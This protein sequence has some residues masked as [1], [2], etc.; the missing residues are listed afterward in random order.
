MRFSVGR[1]ID[2]LTELLRV[3]ADLFSRR[4]EASDK[5]WSEIVDTRRRLSDALAEGRVSDAAFLRKKL[6]GL[7]RDYRRGVRSGMPLAVPAVAAISSVLL[8]GCL[9]GRRGDDGSHSVFV[10]GDRVM[11]ADPGSE[12]VIPDLIPP[13]RQWYIVDDVG[14]KHWLGVDADSVETMEIPER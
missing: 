14:L 8:S 9:S 5:L 6:D 11:L 4:R 2:F 3:F 1:I 7:L 12:I 13:A 10:L